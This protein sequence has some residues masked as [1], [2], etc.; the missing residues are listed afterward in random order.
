MK[1]IRDLKEKVE[2]AGG[3]EEKPELTEEEYRKLD[4]AELEQVAGGAAFQKWTRVQ[5]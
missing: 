2:K 5:E 3:K 1:L 4:D